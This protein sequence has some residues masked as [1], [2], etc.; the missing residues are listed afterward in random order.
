MDAANFLWRKAGSCW[1]GFPVL[2]KSQA[3]CVHRAFLES[4]RSWRKS[5]LVARRCMAD[6]YSARAIETCMKDIKKRSQGEVSAMYPSLPVMVWVSEMMKLTRFLCQVFS[7]MLIVS[8]TYAKGVRAARRRVLMSTPRI[9]LSHA[10]GK[11]SN[12]SQETASCR[13][14]RSDGPSVVN[15]ASMLAAPAR[16]VRT[17]VGS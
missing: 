11:S 10:T 17:W 12:L 2:G 7:R 6:A 5:L 3:C 9:L 1:D 15:M 13:L 14:D 4:L 8:W 16:S